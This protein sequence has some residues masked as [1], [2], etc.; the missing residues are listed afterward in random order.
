M[1]KN[2]TM[3]AVKHN[4]ISLNY[5]LHKDTADGELVESTEGQ[6]PLVFL[7]GMGQMI[8][9]FEANVVDLKEGDTFSFGIKSENAY[10]KRV[11]EAL[12]ELPIDMFKQEGK[13][14]EAVAVG[15]IL[16]MQDQNGQV[17]PGKVLAVN[18]TTVNLDMNHPLADQDLHFV[19][20]ILSVREATPE[21]IEH[22][23]VH[24]EGGHQH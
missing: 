6:Q 5:N 16:P 2:K 13:L 19:G 15:N 8:P 12:I 18:E 4:V 17:R 24:G 20:S 7:S 21:E 9:E 3:S 1:Q 10:G 23:H 22:K 14:M 11:E